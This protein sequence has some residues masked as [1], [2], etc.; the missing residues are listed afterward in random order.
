MPEFTNLLQ[1]AQLLP[2]RLMQKNYEKRGCV[3][4][5]SMLIPYSSVMEVA[6]LISL[7]AFSLNE[8]ND[9]NLLEYLQEKGLYERLTPD[10]LREFKYKTVIGMY[11]FTWHHYD[12][13]VDKFINKPLIELFMQ[14]LGIRFPFE[15]NEGSIESSLV[16]LREYCSYVYKNSH[17]R[18]YK[19][20]NNKLG[21]TIQSDICSITYSDFITDQSQHGVYCG[22]IGTFGMG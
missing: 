16:T 7:L 4:F 3:S 1:S 15:M 17:K 11:L 8:E 20:L 21:S 18:A 9:E 19:E 12:N 2:K 14:D 10:K 5:F 6:K 22:L 13:L